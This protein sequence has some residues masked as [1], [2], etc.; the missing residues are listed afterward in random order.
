MK[1]NNTKYSQQTNNTI[2]RN[3]L[4]TNKKVNRPL[5]YI[6]I[7]FILPVLL[8]I[9]TI[10]FGFTR[11]DD[12]NIISK[13][14]SFLSNFGNAPKAFQTN[15]FIEIPSPFYRPLQTFSYMIDIKFSGVNSTWMFHLTNILLLGAIACSLFI[16]L[17][18]FLIPQKLALLSTLI[19]CT[20]P[21]FVSSIAWIPARGDL[22]LTLFT[23]LSIIFFIDFLQKR[24]IIYLFLNWI[25][26]TIA[27]LCKETAAVLPFLYIIYF[28]AFTPKKRFEKI[29]ILNISLYSVSGIF[30][31]LMRLKAI[32]SISN[33]NDSVIGLT[34]FLSNL[35]TIPE[36]LTKFFIPIDL[37]PIPGFSIYKSI[38]GLMIIVLIIF[39]VIK[40]KER[41]IKEKIFCFT[42]FLILMLPSMLYKHPVI[43][44]LDHRFL[45]P[46]IGILLFVLFIIPKSWL[47]KV[48][49]KGYW[50]MIVII[51]L[52]SLFTF[53]K[54]HSYSDPMT[55]YNEAVSQNTNSAIAYNNR[56]IIKNEKNNFNG[57]MDDY[58]KAIDICPNYADAYY[59]RGNTNSN[60]GNFQEAVKDYNKTIIIYP[61]NAD[62]YY[63]RGVAN[64]KMNNDHDAIEDY[65]K[66]INIR[67][68]F[69]E[70]YFNKGITKEKTGDNIGAI[71]DYNKAITIRPNYA[72]AYLNLGNTKSKMRN[73]LGAIEDYNKAIAINPNYVEAYQNKGLLMYL[74]GNFQE[75][76]DNFNKVIE[77]NP[78]YLDAYFNRAIA[79]YNL[80]DFKGTL[81]DCEKVLKINPNYDMA[82]N[83]KVKAQQELQKKR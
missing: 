6:F 46:L 51:V 32:G 27:L 38:L 28:F 62:A 10:N 17:R 47:L 83:L 34:S 73:S 52:L 57:A 24:K 44:Y 20:H 11:F 25:A 65:N 81:E 35:R 42:W 64:A 9:Q 16:L 37:A 60:L 3:S 39:L 66:A 12:D 31:Y 69:V 40:N 22:Q 77:I 72:E 78:Q 36:S 5:L 54:S 45:L 58:N 15:A 8:Y 55:F 49:I 82:L 79:K 13:N 61:N 67:S 74:S 50:L 19:Y 7:A 56:G 23:L 53:I 18:R 68:N 2:K 4:N 30:W 1:K 80:K 21:L 76:I 33:P 41:T 14:I 29:Y 59:N 75:S 48:D 26:F 70:A 71:E 63:N 43:D